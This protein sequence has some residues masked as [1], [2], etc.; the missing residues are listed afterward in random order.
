MELK[1]QLQ[2]LYQ[3]HESDLATYAWASEDNRWAELVFCLLHQCC[4]Q[5]PELTRSA[6][7]ALQSLSLISV[8]K[9]LYL[10][11]RTHENRVVFAYVLRKHGFSD[12]DAEL[13]C[14]VLAHVANC[15]QHNYGGKIQR[16]LRYHGEVMRD[17]L[18]RAFDGTMLDKPRMEYAISYWLQNALSVPISLQQDAVVDFCQKNNVNLQ[19]LWQAVDDLDLNLALV[20]DLLEMQLRLREGE[21]KGGDEIQDS[22]H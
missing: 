15:I 9:M 10:D 22:I 3:Q 18:V 4:E 17:E 8:G 6:V 2:R 14:Q 20:D 12:D 21:T 11:D 13:A 16:F 5:E 1:A 7:A 19:D